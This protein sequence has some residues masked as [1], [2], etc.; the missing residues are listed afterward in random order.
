MYKADVSNEGYTQRRAK[1]RDLLRPI[2][3]GKVGVRVLH[4][5]AHEP[6]FGGWDGSSP[7][8]G[9]RG[10]NAGFAVGTRPEGRRLGL[11]QGSARE[12]GQALT[13]AALSVVGPVPPVSWPSVLGAMGKWQL[14]SIVMARP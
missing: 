12:P 13:G 11:V 14:I 1:P 5:W 2:R 10:S 3:A 6:V 9:A 4:Q 7:L 8:A